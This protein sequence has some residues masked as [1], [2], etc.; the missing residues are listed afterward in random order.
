MVLP[1]NK[2]KTICFVIFSFFFIFLI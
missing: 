1:P 2:K